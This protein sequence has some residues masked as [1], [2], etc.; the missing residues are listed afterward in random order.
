MQV[1]GND[2]IQR[3]RMQR[4]AV[5]HGI[6]Q[7]LVPLH[8]REFLRHFGGNLI[9]HNHPVTLGIGF[10]HHGQ[11]F[12]WSGLCQPEGIAHNARDADA[13]ENGHLGADFFR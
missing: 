11:Q 2:G 10:G 13:G 4:H 7:H 1:G 12:A 8:I 9:P 6:D 3:L 5:C